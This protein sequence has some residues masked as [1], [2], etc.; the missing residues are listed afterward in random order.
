MYIVFCIG[1]A[2][3]LGL[4]L[5][6][7]GTPTT[8]V[9]DEVSFVLDGHDYLQHQSYF[10]PHPPL[11][12]LQ[13]GVVFSLFGYGPF[14]WRILNAVT[15]AAI[16]PLIGW[17]AWRLT[18]RRSAAVIAVVLTL[19]DGQLLVDSRLG[20]INVPYIFYGL[21][22]LVCILR[23]LDVARP[24]RWLLAAGVCFG[25]AV[26]V[27]WLA[28][29]I[30]LPGVA[31]WRWP[32]WFDQAPIAAR[33]RHHWRFLALA[34]G[35][36]P[37]LIYL[38]VFVWHAAWLGLPLDFW[39][40]QARMLRFHLSI[41]STGDPYA[42]PWWGWLWLQQPF[43]YWSQFVNDKTSVVWS[44][45]NPWVWWTG[46]G[47]FLSSL[48]GGWRQPSR[49]FL[50]VALLTTWIPFL[51]VQRV[52][53]SYHALPFGLFLLLLLAVGLSGWWGR[54]RSTVT[55]YIAIATMVFIWFV[56]WYLNVPLT[57]AQYQLRQWLPTWQVHDDINSR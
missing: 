9:S 21:A 40:L 32:G 57:R 51:F 11:G 7:L 10:D 2:V 16:I 50:N 42:Q 19:L 14:T 55:A 48:W 8:I 17:L 52:M 41:P 23:A 4:R 6:H 12:K 22:A 30:V 34:F 36:V 18:R 43:L 5:W 49:R 28:V 15:G 45:P 20:M 56:P 31:M 39:G 46:I 54:R 13:L 3:A 24:R 37:A 25:L 35:V 47:L 1:F 27:K 53:Y 38:L 26:S 44:L 29:L 33:E